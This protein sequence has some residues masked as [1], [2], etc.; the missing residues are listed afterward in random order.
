MKH[1]LLI[2]ISALVLL[3]AEETHAQTLNI[4]KQGDKA[5]LFNFVGLSTLSLNAYQ[6]GIGGKYFI[7]DGMAIRAMLL[8][9]IDNRTT[10][11]T[12]QFTDNS[13]SFGIG[14]GLEYHLPVATNISPYF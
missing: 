13:L 14:G 10:S 7:A 5:V 1:T 6:G 11:G 8:F 12:P 4:A 2:L 9:G 3:G